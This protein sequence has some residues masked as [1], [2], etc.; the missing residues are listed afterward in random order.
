MV[1]SHAI[2]CELYGHGMRRISGTKKRQLNAAFL[3][4]QESV[5]RTSCHANGKRSAQR[6]T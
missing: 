3:L 1:A 5:K 2:D 4:S 6:V